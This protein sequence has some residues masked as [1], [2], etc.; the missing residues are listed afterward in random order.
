[1]SFTR[2]NAPILLSL[3]VI[4][5]AGFWLRV[6]RL[7]AYPPGISND[8]AFNV[9]EPANSAWSGRIPFFENENRPE[10]LY[11]IYGA[12]S[13]LLFGNTIWAFRYTSALWGFLSSA[14]VFWSCRWCFIE[15]PA[16]LRNH[17][18]LLA[19]AMVATAIGHVTLSR[20]IYRASPLT[21]FLAM[22]VGFACLALHRY[23]WRTFF[24]SAVFL[25]LGIYTYT[26]GL[27]A[28]LVYIPLA[29]TLLITRR[30]AIRR[31]LPRFAFT[32]LAV[33]ILTGPLVYMIVVHPEVYFS[34]A[35][36]VSATDSFDLLDS[37][38]QMLQQF[39][40]RG[41]ENPQYNVADAP[42]I[43]SVFASFFLLG[44]VVLIARILRPSS[45]ILLGLLL[46]LATPAL[47]SNEISHG[48]RIYGEFAVVPVIAGASVIPAYWLM[49][50][51]RISLGVA[52]LL[53][54]AGI[55]MLFAVNL[56]SSA[57][58]YF[59]YWD[60]ADR[61]SRKWRIYDREL[62]HS[63]WFFRTDRE[64]LAD[65]LVE[66]DIPLL[67][68]VEELSQPTQRAMLMDAFP[69]AKAQTAPFSLP[70]QTALVLPWSLERGAFL[71]D[72]LHYVLLQDN[73]I[74]ILPPLTAE[75]YDRIIAGAEGKMELRMPESNIPVVARILSLADDLSLQFEDVMGQASPLSLHN[76][77]LQIVRWY[78]PNTIVEKGAQS[79]TLGFSITRPV[80]HVYGAFLQLLSPSW[81][82]VAGQDRYIHRW[83]FPTL[84]WSPGE[85][86]PVE[87]VLDVTDDLP[88]GA[89]RLA[90]GAWTITEGIV[91]TESFSKGGM[92][93]AATIGWVK[94]PQTEPPVIPQYAT[95]VD[96]VLAESFRLLRADAF[97]TNSNGVRVTLFWTALESRPGIDATVF[98]HA[99]DAEGMLVDQ[100]DKLPQNG[101]Y[102]T[103]IWDEGEVVMTEHSLQLSSYDNIRLYAGMYTQPDFARL[104][105]TVAGERLPNDIVYLGLLS[106]L[107]N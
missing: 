49:S 104:E 54:P 98:V 89:Y 46:L 60:N 9:I 12:F 94:V 95:S 58:V 80:S 102:P 35:G 69:Y 77:E 7:D 1:M 14:A 5:L 97:A 21:F 45:V 24:A 30:K 27:V 38:E 81:E 2:V 11:Q 13:S 53:L 4:L 28:P 66:Q 91:P 34:R 75:T 106:D 47:F 25:A 29:L 15:Q 59:G 85:V 99:V 22:F 73:T 64:F 39:F 67:L 82:K 93:S 41:D 10:P 71:T 48:L 84:V 37:I 6:S 16:Q 42:V 43:S 32:G 90:A 92:G 19:A 105:A 44:L 18:G 101:R 107:L 87:F 56:R 26:A 57:S 96:A 79:Y 68:P 55:L 70:E 40:V 51:L 52:G 86:V 61:E 50:R 63:E 78:G 36:D 8:Q 62:N 103:Y 3:V 88:P 31:W 76:D 17:A 20:A 23:S 33:I 72:S 100:S 74:S 65:W 83:L